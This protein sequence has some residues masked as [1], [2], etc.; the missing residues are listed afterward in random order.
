M[1]LYCQFDRKHEVRE[2]MRSGRSD[3]IEDETGDLLFAVAN[4]ARHLDTVQLAPGFRCRI[5]VR[6]APTALGEQRARVRVSFDGKPTQASTVLLG[7]STQ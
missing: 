4:L 7:T 1:L 5:N 3:A 2:A 6:F